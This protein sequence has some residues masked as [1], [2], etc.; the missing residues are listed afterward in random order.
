MRCVSRP[1]PGML[2]LEAEPRRDH[3]G[4]FARLFCRDEFRQLGVKGAVEQAN[5]SHSERRGTLR[6]LHYQLG[7]SA[8]TK[9]V[10]C[11]KGAI[12]DVVLD[13][14]RDPLPSAAGPRSS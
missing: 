8:E 6:G 9:I 2:V 3:R 7:P 14:R 1:L 12:H 11:P 4:F 5:L 10:G 13:L